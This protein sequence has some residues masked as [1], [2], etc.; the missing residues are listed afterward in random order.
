MNTDV[1]LE[2]LGEKLGLLWEQAQK[3]ETECDDQEMKK[4]ASLMREVMS[5]IH[6]ARGYVDIAI[7]DKR[8]AE[9][10]NKP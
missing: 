5:K 1:S 4:S 7:H 10:E 6:L 8:K 3:L 9:K 2:V